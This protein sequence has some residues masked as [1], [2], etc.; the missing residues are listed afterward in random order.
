MWIKRGRWKHNGPI[1][2]KSSMHPHSVMYNGEK[3]TSLVFTSHLK[4]GCISGCRSPNE[5]GVKSTVFMVFRNNH[6]LRK[7]SYYLYNYG[8]ELF[9]DLFYECIIFCIHSVHLHKG[10]PEVN[11]PVFYCQYLIS[12][13]FQDVFP[14]HFAEHYLFNIQPGL[15]ISKIII[16]ATAMELYVFIRSIA[17]RTSPENKRTTLLN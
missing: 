14:S 8:L 10:F 2:E 15:C 7:F 6:S 5:M 16:L 11:T 4:K 9:H 12:V 3:W 13:K 1:R 17:L